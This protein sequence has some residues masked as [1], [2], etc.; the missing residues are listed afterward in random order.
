MELKP[1][2]KLG[3]LLKEY[4][5]L[6]EFLPTVS[7]KYEALKNPI[8]RR[9]MLGRATLK[10]I[11]E[12][13]GIELGTLIGAIEGAIKEAEAPSDEERTRLSSWSGLNEARRST[14]W[15]RLIGSSA[16]NIER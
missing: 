7:P 6:I 9:T 11:A 3:D 14:R 5:Y 8:L 10:M 16:S 1:E 12:R 2:T 15:T 13:G 4:P